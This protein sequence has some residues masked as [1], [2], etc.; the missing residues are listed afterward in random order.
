MTSRGL[1]RSVF[2]GAFALIASSAMAQAPASFIGTYNGSQME[3][4]TELRLEANGRYEYYLSYGA[5]DETSQGTWTA[6]AN[7]IVLTSDPVKAPQ[8]Q[9]VESKPGKRSELVVRLD[10]PSPMEVHY[11][12]V[13]LLQPDGNVAEVPFGDGP[14]HIPMTA[15]KAPSKVAVAFAAYQVASP[16]YDL[17]TSKHDLH[18]RFVPNDLGK[19]GFDRHRLARDG[20]A[21]VLQRFD[22]TLRF[23]KEPPQAAAPEEKVEQK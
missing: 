5:L 11:F 3:V 10:V 9:L 23:R 22:R 20:D 15:G 4:G 1:V 17:T 18:F 14:L 2:V 19:V 21:F 13:F 8:F 12:S 16:P 7:G 6:D